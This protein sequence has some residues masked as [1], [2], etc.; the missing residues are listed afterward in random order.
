MENGNNIP[1][2]EHLNEVPKSSW[3]DTKQKIFLP[4]SKACRNYVKFVSVCYLV[5]GIGLQRLENDHDVLS[6][7]QIG[8]VDPE[9][10]V[11]VYFRKC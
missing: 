1:L 5:C 10:E 8:L 4:N 6:M 9:K 11:H 2:D 3:T 7:C